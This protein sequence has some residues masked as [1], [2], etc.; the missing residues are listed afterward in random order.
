MRMR[1]IYVFDDI[2]KHLLFQ[3]QDWHFMK[4]LP[5]GISTLFLAIKD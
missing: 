1:H 5:N 3:P 4:L 2:F